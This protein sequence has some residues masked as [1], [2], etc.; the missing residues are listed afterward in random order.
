[1]HVATLHTSLHT[2]HRCENEATYG[3]LD[4]RSRPGSAVVCAVKLECGAIGE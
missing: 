2:R 4:E 1:M 3:K